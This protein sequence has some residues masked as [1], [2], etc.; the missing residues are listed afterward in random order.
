MVNYAKY[1]LVSF[2][3][4]ITINERG[5]SYFILIIINFTNDLINFENYY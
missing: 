1:D 2:L 3:S 4:E 5:R